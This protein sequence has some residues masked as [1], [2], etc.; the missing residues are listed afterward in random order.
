[1]KKYKVDIWFVDGKRRNDWAVD[2][3]IFFD[4]NIQIIDGNSKTYIFDY[5]RNVCAFTVT[6]TDED[7]NERTD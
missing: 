4:G 7:E 5:K 3:V 1:M 6:P 2:D